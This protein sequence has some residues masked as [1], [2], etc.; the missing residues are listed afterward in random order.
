MAYGGTRP[1]R[2]NIEFARLPAIAAC[3]LALCEAARLATHGAEFEPAAQVLL[4]V[5]HLRQQMISRLDHAFE[6]FFW[7]CSAS[8]VKRQS[9]NPKASINW[10]AVGGLAASA[11][12]LRQ[13]GTPDRDAGHPEHGGTLGIA[14]ITAADPWVT[15]SGTPPSIVS[16]PADLRCWCSVNPSG[17]GLPDNG[18]PTACREFPDTGF[19]VVPDYSRPLAAYCPLDFRTEHRPLHQVSAAVQTVI[20]SAENRMEPKQSMQPELTIDFGVAPG[21]QGL[22]ARGPGVSVWPSVQAEREAYAGTRTAWARL[23]RPESRRA[24]GIE[25]RLD[26]RDVSVRQRRLEFLNAQKYASAPLF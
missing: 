14:S 21:E 13:S 19:S 12:L 20:R 9:F 7:Q 3:R 2:K 26:A 5:L 17:C 1:W 25:V 16:G 18:L 4:I 23:P 8:S 24:R 10:G 6:G 11:A 15:V 22:G